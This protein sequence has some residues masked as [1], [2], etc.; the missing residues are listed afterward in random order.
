MEYEGMSAEVVASGIRG[1]SNGSTMTSSTAAGAA[2]G[3]G[4]DFFFFVALFLDFFMEA[5]AAMPTQQHNRANRR[6]HAMTGMKEPA[7]PDVSE[8]ELAVEPEESSEVKDFNE[9]NDIKEAEESPLEPD[10]ESHGVRVVVGVSVGTGGGTVVATASFFFFSGAGVAWAWVPATLPPTIAATPAAAP[11]PMPIFSGNVNP[12]VGAGAAAAT[13]ATV[14]Q[15]LAIAL[16]W[17]QMLSN[18]ATRN[19]TMATGHVSAHDG[20]SKT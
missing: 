12:F 16:A 8:P 5:A 17:P 14:P 9:P 15:G 18:T 11:T 1:G 10:E 19:D 2:A 13:G 7:E 4:A 6:T 20:R 3:A